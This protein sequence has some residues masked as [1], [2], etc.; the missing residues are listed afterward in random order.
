MRKWFLLSFCL[1]SGLLIH[2]NAQQVFSEDFEGL[3]PPTGWTIDSHSSNWTAD[4]SNY[5]G[6]N[7]PEAVL[8]WYPEFTGISRLIS[9]VLDMSGKTTLL[10]QFNHFVDHYD[11]NYQ[12]GVATR[13]NGSAWTDVWTQ[14]ASAPI[15]AST[16]MIPI[17]DANVNSST[18][19]FCIYFSGSSSNIN[20]WAIDNVILH[21][22]TTLDAAV[23]IL[24]VPVYF[25]GPKEVK[26]TIHNMGLTNITS[27]NLN[28]QLEGGEVNTGAISGL[29]IA[30]GGAYEFLS[31][32][33]MSPL[34]GVQNLKV[35]ISN[36]NG[37]NVPDN[38]PGN[39][40]I[41]KIL[42][43]PTQT[44]RRVP[45]Y[46]EFTSSTCSPCASFNGS[47]LNPFIALKGDQLV[48]VKYQM[49]WPNNGDPYYT[50]EGGMRRDYYGLNGVPML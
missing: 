40:T 20:S 27:F 46:E 35:W 32:H 23:T 29:N 50:N 3:F 14:T 37:T 16:V 48:L 30:L 45:F 41:S 9:P 24:D 33:L 43:I 2:V 18:F 25:S 49:N 7:A 31:T 5:A 44:L 1:L 38:V 39:D 19:Q 28:W 47:T 26:G 4:P 6:C 11:G 17:S 21:L 36:V 13:S 42:R 15:S 12:L 8:F 22:P 10:L 34:A